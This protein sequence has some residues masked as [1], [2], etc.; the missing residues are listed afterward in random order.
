MPRYEKLY[1][2]TYTASMK[3]DFVNIVQKALSKSTL[4]N[5]ISYATRKRPCKDA[6]I[7]FE[8]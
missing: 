8:T 6:G 3:C 7:I 2:Y 4:R 1:V 5:K